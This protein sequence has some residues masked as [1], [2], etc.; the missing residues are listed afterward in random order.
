LN[1]SFDALATGGSVLEDGGGVG[2]VGDVLEAGGATMIVNGVSE[3]TACPSLT[4]IVTP[5]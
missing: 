5:G 2:G 4:E 3:A 1:R